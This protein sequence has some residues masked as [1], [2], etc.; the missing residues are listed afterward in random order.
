MFFSIVV[1]SQY[2]FLINNDA[3]IK[4]LLINYVLLINCT[5]KHMHKRNNGRVGQATETA[6]GT[7]EFP[8]PNFY[9]SKSLF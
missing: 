3:Y 6:W 4:V 8:L 2:L 7:S 5:D 1:I 9:D